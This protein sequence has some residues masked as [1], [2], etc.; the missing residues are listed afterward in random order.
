MK[1]ETLSGSSSNDNFSPWS[2]LAAKY[3]RSQRARIDRLKEDGGIDPYENIAEE[4]VSPT[5]AQK[6]GRALLDILRLRSQMIEAQ[7]NYE[8]QMVARREL[9]EEIRRAKIEEQEKLEQQRIEAE[10][11]EA[12]KR[13]KAIREEQKAL[14]GDMLTARERLDYN[15]DSRLRNQRAQELLERNLNERLTK[16]DQLEE[17]ALGGNPDV[18]KSTRSYNG[19]EIPVY[20]LHGFPIKMLTHTVDYRR[21]NDS[22]EI[23]TE[24][25][26]DIMRDPSIWAKRRDIAEQADGFGTKEG[27][28]RGNTI[29]TSYTNSE[30]NLR[31]RFTGELVYGFSQVEADSVLSI[32]NGDGGTSNMEGDD[33]TSIR[34]PSRLNILEGAE[35]IDNYNEVLL[36]RYSENGMPK[37]PDFIV[38]ENGRITET[39]LRHAEYFGI[40]IINLDMDAYSQKTIERGKKILDSLSET[41]SYQ[42]INNKIA[43]VKSISYYKHAYKDIDRVGRGTDVLSEE[44]M[45]ST[46]AYYWRVANLEL[47][48]RIDFMAEVLRKGAAEIRAATARHERAKD[49]PEGLKKFNIISKDIMNDRR[50]STVTGDSVLHE[51]A[52]GNCSGITIEMELEGSSRTVR[53]DISDGERP[54]DV[55][56][57]L[58]V[59]VLKQEDFEKADSS[60]YDRLRPLVD[61]YFA[62]LRE[63]REIA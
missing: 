15:Y 28:A 34:D 41:D 21:L 39:M 29:S 48:K 7:R 35:G 9:R 24:T 27:N 61:E 63:N 38:A 59:G 2:K 10:R 1:G 58:R 45:N 12:M 62:A 5:R 44:N 47:K 57:A 36:R 4:E 60:Y 43:E 30:R 6:A 11:A 25:Y 55:N 42:E 31:S 13:E 53:T 40:P 49:Y 37:R 20:T 56:E 3:D 50:M 46:E 8:A 18:E 17:E 22:G 23:G 33:E 54:Y 19:N 14:R 51:R 32:T 16:I 52:M 26:K